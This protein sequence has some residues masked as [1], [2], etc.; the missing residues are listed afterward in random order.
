M[1]TAAEIHVLGCFLEERL[2]CF[3]VDNLTCDSVPK[4]QAINAHNRTHRSKDDVDGVEDDVDKSEADADDEKGLG[5]TKHGTPQHVGGGIRVSC[6][7]KPL[8][9][10]GRAVPL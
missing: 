7:C 5:G 3:N 10:Y 1:N 8:D 6:C 9:K 4:N 2:P